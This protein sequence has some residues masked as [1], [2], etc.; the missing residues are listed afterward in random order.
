MPWLYLIRAFF[1]PFGSVADNIAEWLAVA[2]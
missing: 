2:Y 1:L